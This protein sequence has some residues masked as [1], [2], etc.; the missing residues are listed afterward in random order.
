MTTLA[1]YLNLRRESLEPQTVACWWQAIACWSEAQVTFWA[2]WLASEVGWGQSWKT[3]PLTGGIW[4]YLWV[5]SVRIE[6]MLQKMIWCGGKPSHSWWPEV[7][8]VK[9]TH[10]KDR[11]SSEE[12]DFSLHGKEKSWVFPLDRGY[13]HLFKQWKH[14][15]DCK[16]LY[17][18]MLTMTHCHSPKPICLLHRP[19]SWVECTC[20]RNH[21][22]CT[23]QVLNGKWHWFLHSLQELGIALVYQGRGDFGGSYLA[24]PSTMAL[25]PEVRVPMWAL[26]QLVVYLFQVRIWNWGNSHRMDLGTLLGLLC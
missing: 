2:F 14:I 21:H 3:E 6:L 20:G 12:L 19:N 15:W 18:V 25:P 11:H 4:P 7:W 23:F 16:G 8:V 22:P 10:R 26:C 5:G 13:V 9:K 1:N 17:L 24:F